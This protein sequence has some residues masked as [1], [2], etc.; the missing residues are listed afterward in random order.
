MRRKDRFSAA[1]SLPM[2]TRTWMVRSVVPW[3]E[4]FVP[5][6]GMAWSAYYLE[7]CVVWQRLLSAESR[8]LC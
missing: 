8:L 6:W 1:W 7:H 2:S 3:G 4:P 5:E